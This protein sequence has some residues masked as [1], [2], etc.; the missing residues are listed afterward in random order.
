MDGITVIY[1]LKRT[2][3]FACFGFYFRISC[4]ALSRVDTVCE[5]AGPALIHGSLSIL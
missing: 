4:F 3:M 5:N 2:C 1:N